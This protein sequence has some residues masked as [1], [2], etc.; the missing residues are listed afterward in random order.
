MVGVLP[1]AA[2]DVQGDL[3]RGDEGAEELL[4]ELRIEG[5]LA[6]PR[7]IRRE[8]DVVMEE[9]PPGDVERDV[10]ERFVER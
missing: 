1:V 6:E 5:R 3:R 10:R 4:G 7:C 2:G 8:F 9:R